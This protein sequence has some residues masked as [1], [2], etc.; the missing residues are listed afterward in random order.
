MMQYFVLE[1]PPGATPIGITPQLIPGHDF[2]SRHPSGMDRGIERYVRYVPFSTVVV[3]FSS[4][5]LVSSH[6][7][8][9]SP[10]LLHDR[11]GGRW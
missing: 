11:F 10:L 3:R 1:N 4:Y 9:V 5:A 7:S 8:N 2:A 6:L